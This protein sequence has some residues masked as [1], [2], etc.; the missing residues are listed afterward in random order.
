MGCPELSGTWPWVDIAQG[1]HWLGVWEL[2]KGGD[3][4]Y[5]LWIAE[6]MEAT[7]V[8]SLALWSMDTEETNTESKKTQLQQLPASQPLRIWVRTY[9]LPQ[10]SPSH[11]FPVWGTGTA[12]YPCIYAVRNLDVI[13]D[14]SF[15][16]H[17]HPPTKSYSVSYLKGDSS[18]KLPSVH[19]AII[20]AK[21]C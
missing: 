2:D 7:L 4:E 9:H 12:M 17:L 3:S 13:H 18:P 1:K 15:S 8:V 11:S 20:W 6:E 10:T 21:F 14:S 19:T 5:G 16:H